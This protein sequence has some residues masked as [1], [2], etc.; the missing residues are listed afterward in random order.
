ML[1]FIVNASTGSIGGQFSHEYHL[2]TEVGEDS[3]LICGECD[4]ACNE[5]IFEEQDEEALQTRQCP[6]CKRSHCLENKKGIEI[7][8]TFYLASRYTQPFEATFTTK[9]GKREYVYALK[10]QSRIALCDAFILND[11]TLCLHTFSYSV[12]F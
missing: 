12:G 1:L 10:H 9:E 3:I 11:F 4:F 8:H 5:E 2:L 6:N 7:G